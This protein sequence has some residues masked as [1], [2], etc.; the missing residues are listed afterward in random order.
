VSWLGLDGKAVVI[1]GAGGIG[2][3]IARGYGGVGARVA[4]ID[5]DP[6][7]LGE[8]DD[9]AV[10]V[11][12]DLST[13]DGCR[14][15]LGRATAELG[16]LDVF[17]H[18]VGTNLRLPIEEYSDA[19]VEG[20][21]TL[22]LSSAIWLGQ[23]AAR[24]MR[25]QGAGRMVFLSS[26]AS[27]LA[28]AHHGP[29]AATKGAVNQLVRVMANELAPTGITVNAVAPGYIETDLTSDYLARP[30]KRDG[31]LALIPAGRFGTADEVVGPVLFL[32]SDHAGFVTG[33]VLAIDGARTCV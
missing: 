29:Y 11:R 20:I 16:G 25:A 19:D 8:L 33:Q 3:A 27:I 4:V 15:A 10:G 17:V 31:L 30:G 12:G 26:V 21:V 23:E 2:S 5:R 7:R 28:H 18:A 22:N 32:S 13:A 14:E 6:A 1:A 24:R 9:V